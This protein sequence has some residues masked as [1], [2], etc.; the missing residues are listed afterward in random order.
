MK[1]FAEGI[2]K[3]HIVRRGYRRLCEIGASYGDN[4][5]TLLQLPSITIDIVD[6]CIDVDLVE[7]YRNHPRVRVHKGISLDVLG[8]LDGPFDCILIDGDHN[9]YTVFHELETIDERGLLGAGGTIFFHDV[10]W[11][12]GR[13]DM[14]YQP[15]LIPDP[16]RQPFKRSGLV[17]GQ[18]AL[19]DDSPNN[20]ELANA[21]HE[22]GP[23]NG[24]LTAIEDF[25]HATGGKYRFQRV[26]AEYGLG[27]LLRPRD[28]WDAIRFRFR[29]WPTPAA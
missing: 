25:V 10:G 15:E 18:S 7:K 6:P 28:R 27:I 14:Y 1:F 4:T 23:R 17:W 13:R 16:Y 21:T 3:P 22:G 20:R 24:V 9:W 2:V 26:E 8:T 29:R 5:D 19:S 12:Y 11:P